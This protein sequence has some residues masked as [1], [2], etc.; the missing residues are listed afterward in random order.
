VATVVADY[1]EGCQL[2][3]TATMIN[4]Y[5]I[6]EVIRGHLGTIKFMRDGFEII[7]DSPKGGA[8]IPARL[9]ETIK[10]E[11]VDCNPPSSKGNGDTEA[12]WLNFLQCVR[13]R[14]RQTLSTP[15]LGAAAFTTVNLGVLSYREGRAL[16]WDKENRKPTDANASWAAKWEKRSKSRGKPNQVLGWRA[17][18]TGSLLEP[19]DYQK[20]AGPWINGKDPA[21][22]T[23]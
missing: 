8:G 4:R 12:L 10:G 15:E 20:L 5:P 14:N 13:S 18:D 3:I 16:F 6:E 11:Y 1:D 22:G 9:E 23:S 21:N 2:I 19:P 17:G 7:P